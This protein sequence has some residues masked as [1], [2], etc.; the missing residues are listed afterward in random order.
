MSAQSG[1]MNTDSGVDFLKV[2][3]E[4][5]LVAVQ[6]AA[7]TP[8]VKCPVSIC[9]R[10]KDRMC[11]S[12]YDR[13]IMLTPCHYEPLSQMNPPDA[14]HDVHLLTATA[15]GCDLQ[16]TCRALLETVNATARRQQVQ[17]QSLAENAKTEPII[18]RCMDRE[19]LRFTQIS[20]P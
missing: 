7:H 18:F 20:R 19:A 16:Q 12:K 14:A 3:A 8:T 10:I 2:F 11:H 6:P 1:P 5:L 9:S 15:S 13:C 4:K 17:Q